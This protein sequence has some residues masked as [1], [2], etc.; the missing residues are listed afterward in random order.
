M[1]LFSSSISRRSILCALL[2]GWLSLGVT[3]VH[4]QTDSVTIGVLAKRGSEVAMARWRATADYL[5]EQLPGHGFRVVPMRFDEIPVLLRN[6]L[7]DFIIVN[8]AIYVEMTVRFGVRRVVTLQNRVPGQHV[9]H[10]GGVLF[11]LRR[12]E[13][14]RGLETLRGKRLAAVHSTSFG[15]WQMAMDHLEE[16][17]IPIADLAGVEFL[18][19]HDAVVQSVLQGLADVGTVRSGTLERLSQ[20][21]KLDLAQIRVLDPQ[22]T[23]DFPLLNSTRLYPEWPLA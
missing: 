17:G 16:A 23:R 14:I 7:V 21:R 1:H 22:Q 18:D 11:S 4:G 12:N 20:E 13:Q 10:F 15:G 2:W 9:T 19:T 3:L 8:P 5:N 6:Q